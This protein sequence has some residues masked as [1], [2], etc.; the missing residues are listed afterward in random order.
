MFFFRGHA[1]CGHHS[2]K[3][4]L[5]FDPRIPWRSWKRKTAPW[6]RR[7]P[8]ALTWTC[9]SDDSKIDRR[10]WS[11]RS[12]RYQDVCIYI[13]TFILYTVYSLVDYDRKW[14]IVWKE[15]T[16]NSLNIRFECSIYV[17]VGNMLSSLLS[18]SDQ[19]RGVYRWSPGKS[20]KIS[21]TFSS[22]VILLWCK[23]P[24]GFSFIV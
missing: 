22:H 24:S 3:L 15:L 18:P 2:S 23:N 8:G 1:F 4:F 7:R 20:F 5:R 13:Y 17:C 10:T 12:S 6:H 9:R 14:R 16:K 21:T 11:A 19:L